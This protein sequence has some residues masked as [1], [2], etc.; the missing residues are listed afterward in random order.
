[1]NAEQTPLQL[2]QQAFLEWM[3]LIDEQV[4][5]ALIAFNEFTG[6]GLARDLEAAGR[7]LARAEKAI[8]NVHV[9]MINGIEEGRKEAG[10]QVTEEPK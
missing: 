1:M 7:S 8:L 6:H 4:Q 5:D 2:A 9:I 3:L 10:Q